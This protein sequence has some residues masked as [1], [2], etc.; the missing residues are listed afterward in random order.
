[1]PLPLL[2]ADAIVLGAVVEDWRAAVREAGAALAR[3]GSAHPAY[4]DEMVRM[5]EEHGPYVVIAPGLALAH[6]RPGPEV[7]AN[8]LAIVTLATPVNFGHPHNDPV[9]VVLGLAVADAE[10][11]LASV[12]Q[13]AN[14]FNDDRAIPALAAATTVEEVQRIMGVRS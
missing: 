12:A 6:A 4:A 5:I 14:V 8:G 3:S 1:M 2:T 11:H 9:S 10:S 7:I 13:L